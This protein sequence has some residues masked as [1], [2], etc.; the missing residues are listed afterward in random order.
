MDGSRLL[1]RIMAAERG[2]RLSPE[3]DGPETLL[4][5]VGVYLSRLLNTRQG[6][7]PAAPELGLPDITHFVQ[8]AGGERMRDLEEMMA[9]VI[10]RYE[11]RLRDVEVR[12]SPEAGAPFTLA[13]TL[14]GK[15]RRNDT[16]LPVVFETLL[17]PDGRIEVKGYA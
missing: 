8:A 17:R 13:F 9:A 7:T 12:H 5:S 6:S 15:V 2:R 14:S 16:L 4:A 3:A 11:P 10:S 1:E